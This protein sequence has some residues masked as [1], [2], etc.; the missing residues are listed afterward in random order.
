ME[1]RN[2]DG[3]SQGDNST[4][5]KI[6]ELREK[7]R[8]T[9]EQRIYCYVCGKALP[10]VKGRVFLCNNLYRCDKGDCAPGGKK[11]LK[12]AKDKPEHKEFYDLFKKEEE[13]QEK[14]K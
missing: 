6:E 8:Q 3:N 12:W 1:S 7:Y 11:W 14:L 9:K 5:K 10:S 2:T 4:S 13:C